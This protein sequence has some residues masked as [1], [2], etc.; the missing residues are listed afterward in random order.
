M[1]S[2]NIVVTKEEIIKSNFY[3]RP[4]IVLLG[5]G[6]SRAAILNGDKNGKVLPLMDDFVDVM[7]LEEF[8][9]KKNI[10]IN[11]RNF[12]EIFS[13][14]SEN[15]KHKN[16]CE[17]LE[18]I[19]YDYFSTLELPNEVT[20]YDQLILS[21]REK[22]VI[23]T[24]NWDLFLVQAIKRNINIAQPP[25]VLFLHGNV[26]VSFCEEHEIVGSNGI[27]CIKCRKPLKK[28]KLLYPIKQ[29]NY[30]NDPFIKKEWEALESKLKYGF[31]FTLFGYS[32]PET[33]KEAI[34]LIKDAWNPENKRMEFYEVIDI[35][36]EFE[37]EKNWVEF[38]P[39]RHANYLKHFKESW[40]GTYPR[41]TG[42]AHHFRHFDGRPLSPNEL[43][44]LKN[45]DNL[46]YWITKLV[47]KE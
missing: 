13:D 28:T 2:H 12:E 29:K 31:M 14:L 23:A 34:T 22:D 27:N 36:S 42:E 35:K 5:A 24:F 10:V 21:L 46:Q 7:N 45:L 18:K 37:L 17:E 15:P 47:E 32:A 40:L 30:N 20:I 41:R 33:D 1:K 39:Y 43:P 38:D 44:D 16:D 11:N 4:H 26:S 3:N 8:F 6:A 9:N 19:I 25:T